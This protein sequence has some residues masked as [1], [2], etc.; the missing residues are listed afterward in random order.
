MVVGKLAYPTEWI[1]KHQ[2]SQHNV[3]LYKKA[4]QSGHRQ[5]RPNF[6][7]T[8]RVCLFRQYFF[9]ER[10]LAGMEFGISKNTLLPRFSAH[11]QAKQIVY[12][13]RNCFE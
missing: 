11:L 10:I 13:Y 3:P 12:V 6:S 5:G 2:S 9:I 1:I 7:K 8:S 4:L